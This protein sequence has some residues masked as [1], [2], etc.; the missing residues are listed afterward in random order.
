MSLCCTVG[1]K[2]YW[3]NNSKKKFKKKGK[4]EKLVLKGKKQRVLF[5]ELIV[6][7]LREGF[8]KIINHQCFVHPQFPF[9][10]KF[11]LCLSTSQGIIIIIL[12][13]KVHG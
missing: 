10:I 5:L 9:G 3:E 12:Y 11:S 4:K 7:K 8:T 13:W 2:L 1:K 6:N